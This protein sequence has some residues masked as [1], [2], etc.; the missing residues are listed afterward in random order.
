VTPDPASLLVLGELP[1]TGTLIRQIVL[2]VVGAVSAVAVL[3][4]LGKWYRRQNAIDDT[5][6]QL[7]LSDIRR[8]RA[9]GAI[10]EQEYEALRR[11]A[12]LAAGVSPDKI[13]P[14][15]AG[16]AAGAGQAGA[17]PP[18]AA[19]GGV[20]GTGAEKPGSA[21]R[22]GGA[23]RPGTSGAAQPSRPATGQ[24]I[25]RGPRSGHAGDDRADSPGA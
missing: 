10:T 17:S 5:G 6:E 16:K 18:G 23:Q 2:A 7:T 13:G 15:P 8:M 1:D 9:E 24:P 12:L 4:A 25:D 20:A 19:D 11:T 3:V 22:P 21:G 14:A